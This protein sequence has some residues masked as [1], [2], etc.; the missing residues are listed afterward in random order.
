MSSTEVKIRSSKGGCVNF[1][2][3]ISTRRRQGERSK[4]PEVLHT[5]LVDG[6]IDIMIQY[7]QNWLCFNIFSQRLFV[8]INTDEL[9]LKIK[10]T[11]Q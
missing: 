2:L 3:W 10:Y 1:V 6:P 8:E 11:D 9:E 4:I 7:L 5:S